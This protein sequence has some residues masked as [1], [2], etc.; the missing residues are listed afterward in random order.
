M[1]ALVIEDGETW[2]VVATPEAGAPQHFKC[3]TFTAAQRLASL[4]EQPVRARPDRALET[5]PRESALSSVTRWLAAAMVRA[6]SAFQPEAVLRAPQVLTRTRRI[7]AA[8][9]VIA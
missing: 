4:L 3:P 5:P 7:A 8:T 6:A 1:T 2:C 9:Y